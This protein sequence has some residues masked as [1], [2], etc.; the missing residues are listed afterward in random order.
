[1]KIKDNFVL[2][3]LAD[4]Y[5]VVPVGEDAERLHGIIR[6]NETGAFLWKM[7]L[8]D[9]T[10]NDLLNALTAQYSTN[11]DKAKTDVNDFLTTLKEY[12]CI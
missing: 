6:L 3:E 10:E 7:L 11:Y 12:S 1:M 4:E 2:Q 8:K 5:I 9:Q